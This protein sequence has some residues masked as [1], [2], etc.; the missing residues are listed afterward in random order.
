[1]TDNTHKSVL[2]SFERKSTTAAAIDQPDEVLQRTLAFHGG[3]ILSKGSLQIDAALKDVTIISTEGKPVVVTPLG[4]CNSCCIQA[5]D[6]LITGDF[7][8]EVIAK[9]DVEVS[10]SARFVGTIRAGGHV[11]VSPIASEAGEIKIVRYVE[12]GAHTSEDIDTAFGHS[13][14]PAAADVGTV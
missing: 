11:L 12:K 14:L 13:M 3:T 5:D 1:M 7:S 9:G 4:N 8:G 6:V 2:F 10:H